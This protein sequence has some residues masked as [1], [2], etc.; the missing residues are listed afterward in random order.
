MGLGDL[1]KDTFESLR[2]EDVFKVEN[3]LFGDQLQAFGNPLGYRVNSH[4]DDIEKKV[5]QSRKPGSPPPPPPGD[6]LLMPS[7]TDSDRRTAAR[8]AA[9]DLRQRGGRASTILTGDYLGGGL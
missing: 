2:D 4:L 8:K 5:D 6:T 7:L 1:F 9:N 3:K